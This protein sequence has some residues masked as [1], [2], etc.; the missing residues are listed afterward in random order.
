[1][2]LKI[3]IITFLIFFKINTLLSSEIINESEI[4]KNLR[5]LVCQGQSISDSNSEFANFKVSSK[6][7]NKRRKN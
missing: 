4:H 3:I 5:C 7:F 1:M 2:K 6:R